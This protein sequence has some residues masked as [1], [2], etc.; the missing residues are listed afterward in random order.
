MNFSSAATCT[1]CLFTEDNSNYWTAV[2]Y[3]KARNGT[4]KRVPTY[5]NENPMGVN[6]GM[7]VY[8]IPPYDGR[9]RVKAFAPVSSQIRSVLGDIC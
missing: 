3:F 4:Y 5:A 8:Y 7:T 2:M 9:S 1:S 6:D